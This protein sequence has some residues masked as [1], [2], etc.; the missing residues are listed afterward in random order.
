MDDGLETL[1]TTV[2]LDVG[3]E[4]PWEEQAKAHMWAERSAFASTHTGS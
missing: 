2:T 1:V 3:Y 4:S